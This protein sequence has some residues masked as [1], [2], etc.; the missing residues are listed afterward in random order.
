MQ[1]F[2][3]L[4]VDLEITGRETREMEDLVDAVN[5]IKRITENQDAAL[6]AVAKALLESVRL[7]RIHKAEQAFAEKYVQ[8]Q[9]AQLQ[10]KAQE[11]LTVTREAVRQAQNNLQGR[12]TSPAEGRG[13]TSGEARAGLGG[14]AGIRTESNHGRTAPLLEKQKA[15]LERQQQFLQKNLEHVTK[16]LREAGDNVVNRLQ[17]TCATAGL[18]GRFFRTAARR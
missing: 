6:D 3:A 10:A 18:N 8:E 7:D 9:A 14:R 1:E 4:L 5:R 17:T 15:E 13:G 12:A 2:C 11:N 16:E